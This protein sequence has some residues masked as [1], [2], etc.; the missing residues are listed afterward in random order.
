MKLSVSRAAL[1]AAALLTLAACGSEAS[2]SSTAPDPNLLDEGVLSVCT[3]LPFEPFEL[4]RGGEVVGFDVDL[5]NEVAAELEVETEFVNEDFDDIQSGALLNDDAC[6]VAVAALSINGDRARVVDFSSPYF[7]ATQ[8]L[9]TQKGNAAQGL[10]DLGGGRLAVQEGSTGEVYAA[11]HAL[12]S[13]QI[14]K[15]DTKEN[16]DSALAGGTVDAAIYDNN[17]VG[18][19]IKANPSF[20]VIDEFDTGEQYGMAVKKDGDID[21]LR[22]IN[23]VLADIQENGRYDEI[24]STWFGENAA[25]EE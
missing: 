15:F 5:V 19:S 23:T 13:T 17:I 8:V 12:A 25:A 4:E 6:D 11:D 22:V 24:Y 16:V 2:G 10:G 14:V 7:N 9:V 1:T 3:S 18:E 20:Q 21:L